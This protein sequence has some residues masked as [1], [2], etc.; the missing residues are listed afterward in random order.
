MPQCQGRIARLVVSIPFRSGRSFSPSRDGPNHRGGP[1]VSI[2]FR[3]GRSFS[4][5]TGRARQHLRGAAEVSIPFRSGRSF[6]QIRKVLVE[7]ELEFQSPLDRGVLFHAQRPQAS[8][9]GTGPRVS[10]PFRSGRSFSQEAG[11]DRRPSRCVSIPF[12][13]GR[14]FSRVVSRSEP[15]GSLVSIPF[16]S[17]RSFSLTMKVRTIHEMV[18]SAFQSPLDRGVLF[19]GGS[20]P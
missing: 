13:S 4:Q 5:E 3:S 14:S 11:G 6:S 12:R 1:L 20:T 18:P 19:H 9:P 10:I 7:F 8:G 2:P 16:R 17:G 15:T